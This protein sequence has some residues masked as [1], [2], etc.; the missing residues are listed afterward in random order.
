MTATKAQTVKVNDYLTS[1]ARTVVP[2]VVGLVVSLALRAGVDVHGY[3]PE[4][5]AAV[6]AGYYAAV[7]YVERFVDPRAGWLLGVAKSPAYSVIK[8]AASSASAGTLTVKVEADV[9]GL[10]DSIAASLH[11]AGDAVTKAKPKVTAAKKA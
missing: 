9:S 4:I 8:A 11:G 2:I 1:L 5:T 7:H 10:L 6:S 3:A